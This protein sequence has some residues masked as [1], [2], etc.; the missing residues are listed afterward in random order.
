M[1]TQ[2]NPFHLGK[3]NNWIHTELKQIL[4]NNLAFGSKGYVVRAKKFSKLLAKY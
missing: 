1:L 2:C 3:E 4:N